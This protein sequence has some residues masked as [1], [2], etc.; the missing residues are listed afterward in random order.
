M[1][2]IGIGMTYIITKSQVQTQFHLGEEKKDY[3]P[4]ICVFSLPNKV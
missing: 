2:E 4:E 1:L 3:S